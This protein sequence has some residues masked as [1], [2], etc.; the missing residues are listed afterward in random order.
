MMDKDR[1]DKS[2]S[3]QTS[4]SFQHQALEIGLGLVTA[5]VLL[6]LVI[7]DWSKKWVQQSSF[8]DQGWW[9]ESHLPVLSDPPIPQN[10]SSPDLPD[11][12][13]DPPLD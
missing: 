5:P 4:G 12:P 2:T 11:S 1:I 6:G 3:V 8:A 10:Q 9:D 13:L 7:L